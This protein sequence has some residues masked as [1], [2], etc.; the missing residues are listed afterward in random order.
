MD[1]ASTEFFWNNSD[2]FISE[3][4]EPSFFLLSLVI[5]IVNLMVIS[6]KVKTFS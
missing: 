5:K 2:Q 4:Q 6:L 1:R 3:I